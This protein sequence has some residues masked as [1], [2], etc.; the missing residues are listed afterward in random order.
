MIGYIVARG[1]TDVIGDISVLPN[2]YVIDDTD[3]QIVVDDNRS[4]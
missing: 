4:E 3:M 2:A 1:V